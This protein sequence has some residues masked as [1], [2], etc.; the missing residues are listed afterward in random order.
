MRG[1]T[2][3]FIA[4]SWPVVAFADITGTALVI[5][6]DTIEVVGQRIRLHGIDAPR[7]M[8]NDLRNILRPRSGGA[9]SLA[10][11]PEIFGLPQKSRRGTCARQAGGG[12][13]RYRTYGNLKL[14]NGVGRGTREKTSFSDGFRTFQRRC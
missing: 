7:R 9:F 11:R 4:C 6:G 2:V 3:V 8:S 13:A 5:D 12:M 1:L 10:K 14:R